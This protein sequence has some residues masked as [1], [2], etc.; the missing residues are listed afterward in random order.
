MHYLRSTG[1]SV[2][3]GAV[4]VAAGVG[5]AGSAS[6]EAVERDIDWTVRTEATTVVTDIDSGHFRVVGD[7]LELAYDAGAVLIRVPL[8]FDVAGRSVA[9]NVEAGEHSA[10]LTPIIAP[11]AAATF[12]EAP[13]V[14]AEEIGLVAIP[15]AAAA[16]G[17]IGSAIGGALG[18]LIG[19]ITGGTGAGAAAG[20]AT[21]G[22]AAAPGGLAG[23]AA[24]GAAGSMTGGTIGGIVGSVVGVLV[25]AFSPTP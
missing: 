20:A 15:P 21:A 23:R 17:A 1:L 16:G 6:A 24:G 5:A 7:A 9:L 22:L 10:R 8:T 19:C 11:E 2:V 4:V 18:G 25:G 14:R 13:L 3:L 12:S